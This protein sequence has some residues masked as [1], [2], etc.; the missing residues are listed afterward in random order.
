MF[1]YTNGLRYKADRKPL[2]I[3]IK[4]PSLNIHPA[5]NKTIHILQHMFTFSHPIT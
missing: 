1:C 4:E 5:K 3:T 2:I